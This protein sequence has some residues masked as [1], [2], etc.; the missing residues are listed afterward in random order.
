MDDKLRFALAQ[1][2]NELVGT[3][4]RMIAAGLKS[5]SADAR[6]HTRAVRKVVDEIEERFDSFTDG[7]DEIA[8]PLDPDD[9]AK[10]PKK[11]S[12]KKK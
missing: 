8:P 6:K 12:K 3:T 5:L 4:G 9:A 7:L 10:R 11:P 1:L 2:K